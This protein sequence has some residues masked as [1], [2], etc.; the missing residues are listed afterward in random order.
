MFYA[1]VFV[2]LG[3]SDDRYDTIV[4][5]HKG[6]T[7]N[8]TA[9]HIVLTTGGYGSN[10]DFFNQKHPG[11]PLNSSTYPNSTGEG[12]MI[13]ENH[14]AQFRMGDLHLP[15]LSGIE[16]EPGSGRSNFNEAWAMVLTS[17]YRKPRDI[18]INSKGVRFL[19]EDEENADIRERAL[20]EQEDWYFWVVFDEPA[21]LER[22]DDGLENPIIIGW[23]TEMIEAEAAKGMSI[24]KANSL[25]ELAVMMELNPS[26][27]KKTVTT[28]NQ[29]VDAG[30]DPEFHREYLEHKVS[31]APFYAIKVYASVLVT[32]GGIQVDSQLRVIDQSGKPFQG[33]YAAG[34]ILGLG[35]LSGNA[36]CSGMAITPALSFGRILGQVLGE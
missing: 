29:Y 13:L 4:C 31:A 24:K 36:F 9:S 34:E 22:N 23:N 8:L 21:L 25:E 6:E 28:Y 17:V 35:A 11:V 27:V 5:R 10:P 14:Q 32:F 18:Y 26:T 33:I 19:N 1:H 3:R 30:E 2:D 20:V 16:M 7:I 12:T 15:S